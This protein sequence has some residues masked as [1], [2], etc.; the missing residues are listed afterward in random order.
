MRRDQ[1]CTSDQTSCAQPEST[2]D[3]GKAPG[4]TGMEEMEV[5]GADAARQSGDRHPVH[6]LIP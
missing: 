5:L 6:G 1:R 4:L 3:L 2:D